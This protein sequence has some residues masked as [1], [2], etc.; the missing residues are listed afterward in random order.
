MRVPQSSQQ[1]VD[2]LRQAE[3]S[4]GSVKVNKHGVVVIRNSILTKLEGLAAKVMGPEWQKEHAMIRHKQVLDAF[5]TALSRD[6]HGA[7][8]GDR[9]L[10]KSYSRFVSSIGYEFKANYKSGT[11]PKAD[12]LETKVAEARDDALKN[13]DKNQLLLARQALSEFGDGNPPHDKVVILNGIANGL[14]NSTVSDGR[15][16]L[17][18]MVRALQSHVESLSEAYGQATEPNED[19]AQELS[20]STRALHHL[21]TM[22]EDAL[23]SNR[24][25]EDIHLPKQDENPNP[26]NELSS[27][28]LEMLEIEPQDLVQM[29]QRK[30]VHFAGSSN[31]LNTVE[32][33]AEGA[34]I[35]EIRAS[36][37]P[38]EVQT[39]FKGAGSLEEKDSAEFAEKQQPLDPA[40]GVYTENKNGRRTAADVEAA[41]RLWGLGEQVGQSP[42]KMTVS[43]FA[44]KHIDGDL[45]HLRRTQKR[46][47]ANIEANSPQAKAKALAEF[48]ARTEARALARAQAQALAQAQLQAQFQAEI[49]AESQ[50]EIQ[51]ELQVDART[52]VISASMRSLSATD[53]ARI[54]S[55]P[56]SL[57]E[58]VPAEM[59]IMNS[60]R[61]GSPLDVAVR[62]T[63]LHDQIPVWQVNRNFCQ[64]LMNEMET[65]SQRQTA[66]Y[67][68]TEVDLIAAEELARFLMTNPAIA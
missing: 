55:F 38:S 50:S 2:V 28:Q 17:D 51:T 33:A 59:W 44:G 53:A 36:K 6:F 46:D 9:R 10:A 67:T 52:K 61:A 27:H 65:S 26:L 14:T 66:G 20:K 8:V 13:Y 62:A 11:L 40:A 18:F 3:R 58:S 30:H 19:L 42:L 22:L 49:P 15:V 41:N 25:I 57:T 31:T 47:Q 56:L 29:N 4:G 21:S 16:M 39:V 24:D 23:Q 43:E 5:G 35:R 54:D 60:L 45:A 32:A 63:G 48:Q 1:I 37:M 12:V 68:R 64:R 7:E 34:E